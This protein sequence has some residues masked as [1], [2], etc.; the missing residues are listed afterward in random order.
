MRTVIHLP[1]DLVFSI[2]RLL[3][4]DEIMHAIQ[5]DEEGLVVPGYYL[6][7]NTYKHHS[8]LLVPEA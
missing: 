8:Y 7:G 1:P 2:G 5:N 3:K 6:D 4:D